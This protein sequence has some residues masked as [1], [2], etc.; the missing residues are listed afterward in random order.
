MR[1][2]GT[3]VAFWTASPCYSPSTV[4]VQQLDRGHMADFLLSTSTHNRARP[5]ASSAAP[6]QQSRQLS[7]APPVFFP[8]L[9]RGLPVIMATG[10]RLRQSPGA[11]SVL[12]SCVH[13]SRSQQPKLYTQTCAP[14][15]R[16]W[17]PVPTTSVELSSIL[18]HYNK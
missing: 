7:A 6:F 12:S 13:R 17:V 8:V 5:P 2:P 15:S 9:L 10:T 14:T 3:S 4:S 16:S 11:A 18:Y 1:V